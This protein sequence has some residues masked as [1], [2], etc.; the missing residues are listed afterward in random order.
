MPQVRDVHSPEDRKE[1]DSALRMRDRVC[2]KRCLASA[3]PSH[4]GREDNFGNEQWNACAA[5]MNHKKYL[6]KIGK[7]GGKS[8]TGK[9]KARTSE[10]AR[11]AALA[12]WRKVRRKSNG[13]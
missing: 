1:G 12:R 2:A 3:S 13:K 4:D 5:N 8:G 10:Q 11:A 6:S 7:V 9:S